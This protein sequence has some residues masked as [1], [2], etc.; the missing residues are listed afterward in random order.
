[1][2]R[3]KSITLA[4]TLFV[5][6]AAMLVSLAAILIVN[7]SG[8]IDALMA[9]A[10][11]PHYMQM[12]SGE[13]DVTRLASFVEK[14]GGID[15]FQTLEFLNI[16]GAKIVFEGGSLAGSVQDNGFSVQ[17]KAFDFLLDFEGNIIH[18]EDGEIYVPIA[19][20]QEGLAKTG[21]RLRVS[22][23]EFQIAGF[24]RDSQMNSLLSSSKRFLVSENDY[25]AI[26]DI[27]N[28]EYLIEFRLSDPAMLGTFETDYISAGIEANGPAITYPLF[29]ML[30]GFS[31]GLMIAVIL[32]VS[33]L[34]VA[35]TFLC[36]RFTL[37]AEIEEDYREIGVLKAIGLRV[38][39]IQKIYLSKYAAIS[40]AGSMLGFG[41]SF[42]IR[43]L[44]LE[45]IRL[46]MGESE[47]SSLAL[48]FGMI[49]VMLVFLVTIAYVYGVLGRFRKISPAE[50]IRFGILQEKP[51]RAKHFQLSAYT[52]PNINIFLGMKDVLARKKIYAT[53]LAVL[54]ISVFII[55]VPQNLHNTISSN[56]FIT[57][58]GVGNSDLRIDIQQTENIVEKAAE[59]ATFMEND[60][61]IA[62]FVVLT[63]KAFKVKLDDGSEERIKVELGDHSVFPLTY[64]QGRAPSAVDEIALSVVNAR[65]MDKRVGDTITMVIGK[66][67]KRLRVSGIYSDVTNGGKTAKAVFSDKTTDVMW[68][69][70]SAELMDASLIDSKI[71][72]YTNKFAFAKVS[73]IDEYIVQTYGSTIIAIGRASYVSAGIALGIMVLVTLLFIRMLVAKDR[74]SI[75][76][77]KAFGFTNSDIKAQYVARSGFVLIVGIILGTLL[78]NTLG[79]ALAGAVIASFGASSFSFVINPLE[80]YLISPF[81]MVFAV[82]LATVFGTLDAGKIKISENI[83]E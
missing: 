46:Y 12:H 29:K 9:R 64:S 58:M 48:L 68:S 41:L 52:L 60:K 49:G 79:E 36:I 23:K 73:G 24:L 67:E 45:N 7:L 42:A 53:M 31:D 15:E 25:A 56:N 72:E 20:W 50:A 74:F 70:I 8:A 38:S 32:L 62:E 14:H 40:A 76:V 11:T 30:N 65:E 69:V 19:Y 28:V 57:Y 17:S 66:Q 18:V 4:I 82:L 54:V 1:M 78:A 63:T 3:N 75:A 44:L 16:D 47:N 26:K 13:I 22:E 37:L 80:A 61:S 71:E 33:A 6:A 21:D 35:I 39:D 2:L 55:I 10:E 51:D 34:V 59:I 83:K 27:G 81:L 5:A 77:M 43:G